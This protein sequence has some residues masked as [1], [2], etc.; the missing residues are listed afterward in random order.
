MLVGIRKT[1]SYRNLLFGMIGIFVYVGAEVGISNIANLYMAT[2]A[3]QGGLGILVGVAGT[4]CGIYWLL[5]LV[6]RI[7]GGMVGG[8]VSSRAMLSVMGC[9]AITLLLVAIF[10]PK[11]ITVTLM[12]QSVPVSVVLMILC[13]LCTSVM[14]GSIFN[15]AVEGLGQYTSLASGLINTMCVGGGVI[16]IALGAISDKWGFVSSF[17]L[18]ILCFVYL[19]WYALK[20]SKFNKTVNA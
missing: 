19:V 6:G 5:M 2:P 9:A 4:L 1:L 7:L 18:I 3:D 15:M 8:K 10:L 11:T 20:G 16:L 12:N 13:G 17:W 14:S